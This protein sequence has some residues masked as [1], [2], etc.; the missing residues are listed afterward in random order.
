MVGRKGKGK[1][2]GKNRKG[3]IAKRRQ[4]WRS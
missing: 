2:K 3:V 4:S 1:G